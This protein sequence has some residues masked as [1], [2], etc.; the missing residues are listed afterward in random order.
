VNEYAEQLRTTMIDAGCA[1]LA[2]VT[3]SILRLSR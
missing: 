3:P 1:S 2:E